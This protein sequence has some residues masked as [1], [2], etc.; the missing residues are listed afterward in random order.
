MGLFLLLLIIVAASLS[1]VRESSVELTEPLTDFGDLIVR[2]EQGLLKGQQIESAENG[3]Y[4]SF[5]GVPYAK[6]PI[7]PLRFKDPESPSSWEG[8]RNAWKDGENCP[9]ADYMSDTLTG[10]EDCLYLNVYSPLLPSPDVELIPVMV[11]IHGGGFVIGSGESATLGPDYL[12]AEGVLLVT[13]NYRLGPLGFLCLGEEAPGNVGL[14]DQVAALRWVQKNIASFGGNPNQVTIFG[15]SAGGASVHLQM[16]SPMSKGL[17]QGAIA[18]SGTAINPWA[19]QTEPQKMARNLANLVGCPTEDD[20][21]TVQCLRTVDAL[22]LVKMSPEAFVDSDRKR[23]L[24]FAFVPTVDLDVKNSER[25]LPAPPEQL[26]AEKKHHA[27]PLITGLVPYE[28]YL[29]IG[30]LNFLLEENAKK[31]D[32]DWAEI[33]LPDLRLPM[34]GSRNNEA[35]DQ[36]RSFY[37]DGQPL[38]NTTMEGFLNFL[39]DEG[40]GEGLYYSVQHMSEINKAPMYL[41]NFIIDDE[42]NF[43]K[44]LNNLHLPGA[45][46]ADDIGYLFRVEAL[47][48]VSEYSSAALAR[49]RLVRLWTNFAKYGIPI[50]HDDPLLNSS[51]TTYNNVQ[52]NYLEIGPELLPKENFN[53]ERAEF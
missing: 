4:V 33:F 22:K 34:N 26:I 28:G 52:R 50:P 25:F 5:K 19:I 40:F 12:V 47:P 49:S 35:V 10:N 30:F 9:Q 44:Y 38:S 42:L 27:V 51:W 11:W 18:Q 21:A 7:G 14:K 6:P 13:I 45:C 39:S 37:M 53:R 2:V 24:K 17:F 41:Y 32:E 31:I 36:I 43:L 46:H 48:D 23:I 15:E 16:L 29:H 3:S 8:I 20:A 1:L